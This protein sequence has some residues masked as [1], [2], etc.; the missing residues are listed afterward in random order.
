[1]RG[2]SSPNQPEPLST[3]LHEST[4]LNESFAAFALCSTTSA[5]LYTLKTVLD[6]D[7][8]PKDAPGQP[9]RDS[10]SAATPG[11]EGH[12]WKRFQMAR[13]RWQL[14]LFL[15]PAL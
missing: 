8:S 7:G 4:A 12:I 10:P 14:P 13:E 2:W 5:P 3:P 1:M 15:L 9:W 6:L 11:R